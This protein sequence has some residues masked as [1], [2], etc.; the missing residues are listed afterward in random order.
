[1]AQYF[2]LLYVTE[3]NKHYKILSAM[4][5]TVILLLFAATMTAQAQFT[6]GINT[7]FNH[8]G[9]YNHLLQENEGNLAYFLSPN[10]LVGYHLNDHLTVGFTGGIKYF[11][12]GQSEQTTDLSL[13]PYNDA[14]THDYEEDLAWN[15]GA[16]ARY[17]IH[18]TDRLLLF[19]HLC[20]GFGCVYHRDQYEYWRFNHSSGNYEVQ[21]NTGG[22]GVS[23]TFTE[24]T[25]TPGVSY[26]FSKHLSADLYLNLLNVCFTH[27][28]VKYDDERKSTFHQLSNGSQSLLLNPYEYLNQ[29]YFDFPF[30]FNTSL[31]PSLNFGISYTF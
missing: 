19:A 14:T 8:L 3:I 7:G 13:V 23:T 15:A 10:L 18:L 30:L 9:S 5:K 2:S 12:E 29:N 20:I 17:D 1:M 31:I 21:T 27:A 25:L 11:C 16:Y 4:K 6:I 22:S 26:R 28:T 24:A